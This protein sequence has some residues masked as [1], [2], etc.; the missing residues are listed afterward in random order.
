MLYIQGRYVV[1]DGKRTDQLRVVWSPDPRHQQPA[2]LL[3]CGWWH[4]T[5]HRVRCWC[6]SFT[7]HPVTSAVCMYGQR[8]I[9]FAAVAGKRSTGNFPW[10]YLCVCVCVCVCVLVHA[11]A[12]MCTLL[13]V[14]LVWFGL[15]FILVHLDLN[16]GMCLR[17]SVGLIDWLAV[18]YCWCRGLCRRSVSCWCQVQEN[19]VQCL[20]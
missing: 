8:W 18:P 14:V 5:A 17:A 9:L 4:W 2:H 7:W 3:N 16:D 19:Y 15:V 12:H 1:R 6:Q 13:I 10:F 11:C 20:K